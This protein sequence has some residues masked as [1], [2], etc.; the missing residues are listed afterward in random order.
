MRFLFAFVL[1]FS[2]SSSPDVAPASTSLAAITQPASAP[3]AVIAPVKSIDMSGEFVIRFDDR[4]VLPDP[5]DDSLI[6]RSDGSIELQERIEIVSKR[7]KPEVVEHAAPGKITKAM[8]S[9]SE[10]ASIRFAF[11]S[12]EF[13]MVEN[14]YRGKMYDVPSLI[15][16]VQT[17]TQKK[18][19]SVSGMLLDDLP[20][21]L[22]TAVVYTQKV[23]GERLLEARSAKPTKK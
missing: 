6:I 16:S 5:T 22:L 7:G 17:P 23:A 9:E 10:L 19:V 12:E 20:P 11:S 14:S 15:Y 3:A 18:S 4:Q 1:L 21:A 8:L 2:C 13:F